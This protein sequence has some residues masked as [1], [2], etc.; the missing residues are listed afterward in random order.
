MSNV[1]KLLRRELVSL[2]HIKLTSLRAKLLVRDC[3]LL[4]QRV[5]RILP[6]PFQTLLLIHA[7]CYPT[8]MTNLLVS[9]LAS[10]HTY[11]R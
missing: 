7:I 6:F 1:L 2:V 5:I 11:R 4:R 10:H 9:L 3:Y 8:L